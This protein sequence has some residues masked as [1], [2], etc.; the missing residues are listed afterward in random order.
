MKF[1]RK[2]FLSFVCSYALFVTLLPLVVKDIDHWSNVR[3]SCYIACGVVIGVLIEMLISL[4][5]SKD[6]KKEDMEEPFE[7]QEEVQ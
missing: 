2:I 3:Y 1:F 7:E 4:G 6:E 5:K